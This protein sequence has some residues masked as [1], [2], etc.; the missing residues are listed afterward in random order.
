M[1]LCLLAPSTYVTEAHAAFV[2]GCAIVSIVTTAAL[3][4]AKDRDFAPDHI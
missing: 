3:P 4:N 1:E 2:F